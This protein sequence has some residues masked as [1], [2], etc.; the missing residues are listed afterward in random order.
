MSGKGEMMNTEEQERVDRFEKLRAELATLDD[1]ALKTRFWELCHKVMEPVVDLARTH[2]TP[3]IWKIR[4]PVM[5]FFA[6]PAST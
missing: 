1:D 6:S 4:A 2:T 5:T 3:S